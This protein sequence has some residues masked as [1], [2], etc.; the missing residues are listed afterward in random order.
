MTRSYDVIAQMIDYLADHYEDQLDLNMLAERSGYEATYFQKIFKEHVGVS[1]KDVIRYMRFS[2]A[3]EFL[4]DGYSSLDAAN[5][6]GMS[7]GSRLHDLCVSYTAFTPGDIKRRGA[8]VQIS[9]GWYPSELGCMLIGKTP[10]GICWLSFLLDGDKSACILKMKERWPAAVFNEEEADHAVTQNILAVWR[11][12]VDARSDLAL[13][14]HGTNFQV[15]VWQALLS[16]P[17]GQLVSYNDVAL[18]LDRPQANRAVGTAIGK[19]P[20]SLLIPCH[21]VIQSSGIVENYAWGTARKRLL[22]GMEQ[23]TD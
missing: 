13:D 2:K 22:I 17:F 3:E 18:R 6:L 5:E 7:S 4:L 1:P 15:Q 9:Y 19:N 16:I 10:K 8:G 23:A 11:G 12:D 14:V 20:V 21:R